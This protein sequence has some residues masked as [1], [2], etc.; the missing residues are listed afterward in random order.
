[1]MND[2][3]IYQG[4]WLTFCAITK[5]ANEFLRGLSRDDWRDFV[6]AAT[7]LE[8]SIRAGRPPA[9]RS[10]KIEGSK[11]SLFEL[12]ITPPGRRG[13]QLRLLY[14]R[15]RRHILCARGVVKRTGAIS[16]REVTLCE[17]AVKD[18][19]RARH[20]GEGCA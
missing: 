15:R 6:V 13:P 12:R 19:L 3:P 20:E 7:I 10:E 16:R 9:G 17:A 11:V 18:F 8:T 5:Q 2:P 4:Q 1:M 14:I